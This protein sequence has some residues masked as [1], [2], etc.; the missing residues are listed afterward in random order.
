M[1][2][3]YKVLVYGAHIV[4]TI[5]TIMSALKVYNGEENSWWVLAGWISAMVWTNIAL[6]L[7]G[8][9]KKHEERGKTNDTEGRS[10]KVGE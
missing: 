7:Q 9:I 2:N 8:M 1:K 3:N 4:M 10:N 5:M 6:S